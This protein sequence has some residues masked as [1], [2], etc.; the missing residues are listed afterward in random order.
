MGSPF[1][2][3][4]GFVSS[5]V[6]PSPRASEGSCNYL[7]DLMLDKAVSQGNTVEAVRER[8][9]SWLVARTQREVSAN[10][11]RLKSEGYTGRSHLCG[12]GNAVEQ[13]IGDAV[14]AGRYAVARACSAS[15]L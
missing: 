4:A 13:P 6:R 2:S 5:S 3:A 9:D 12:G 7:R 1:T 10:I 15:S 11:D 14:P 8:I